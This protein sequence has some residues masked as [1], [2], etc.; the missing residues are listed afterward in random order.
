M[1]GAY[2]RSKG[3]RGERELCSLLTEYIGGEYSRNLK[4]YQQAQ[5]GDIEQLVGPYLVEA[6]NCKDLKIPQWWNQAVA[7]AAAR[8]AIPCLS[9]RLSGRPREDRWR[10]VIPA[11]WA[12][13]T[14][15]E[16]RTDLRYTMTVGI[17]V[18]AGIVRGER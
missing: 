11:P 10:F 1:T 14:G 13:D 16:W 12:W 5:H 15:K 18:F 2:S 9:Y 7:A 4:Q 8:K 17:E 6:K 3:A